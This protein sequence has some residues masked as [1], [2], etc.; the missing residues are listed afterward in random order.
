MRNYGFIC[1]LVAVLFLAAAQELKSQPNESNSKRQQ[2]QPAGTPSPVLQSPVNDAAEASREAYR[3]E[4]DAKDDEFRADQFA[5]NQIIAKASDRIFWATALNFVIAAI[6]AFFTLRAVTKQAEYAGEQARTMHNEFELMALGLKEQHDAHNLEMKN[7][8]LQG[9]AMDGQLKAMQDA[10]EMAKGQLVA[11]QHQEQAQFAALEE[12]RKMVA[13]NERSVVA[14]ETS[15]ETARE[16]FHVGEAP[17]FGIAKIAPEYFTA[18]DYY[19]PYVKVTFTNGGKTPAWHCHSTAK[20]VVGKT[21]ESGQAFDLSTEWHDLENTFFPTGESRTFGYRSSD[22]RISTE[23]E[24]D[25]AS[26]RTY[27]FVIIKTHYRDFRKVWHGRDFRLIWDATFNNFR[28]Y[29]AAAPNCG[30]C[31]KVESATDHKSAP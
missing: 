31:Q 23:L 6:F 29:D 21:L 27:I 11:M 1:A 22:F 18:S 24:N 13:Q 16:A 4:R 5:Q 10:A 28:D 9:E 7:M 30:K 15:V 12:T 25:L 2:Q 17:Y 26:G 14:A 19:A 8:V 3:K 20:A